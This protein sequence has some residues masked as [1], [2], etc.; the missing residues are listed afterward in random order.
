VAGT[1]IKQLQ[2]HQTY[3]YLDLLY[4]TGL[5]S[6]DYLNATGFRPDI[7]LHPTEAGLREAK[8]LL[9][10]LGIDPERL[11]IGINPGAYF[12]PDKRWLTDRYAALADRLMEELDA[13]VLIF[14]SP[15]EAIIAE[16]MHRAMNNR[17]RNLTGRTDLV[18]LIALISCCRLF[19]SNDSGPMHLASALGVPLVAI[20]GSTDE[21]ATGPYSE[22][23][24]VIHKHVSCSPCLLRECPID[25]RCFTRITV[26]EVFQTACR[27]LSK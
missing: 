18:T 15:Q 20:F 10:G 11:L 5:S 19:I 24:T 27:L 12:G 22:H 1:R 17:P 13:E 26:D 16:Q 21:V 2:R 25:L 8:S 3:Y 6:T 4:Q 23:A 7:S 14:G 9:D